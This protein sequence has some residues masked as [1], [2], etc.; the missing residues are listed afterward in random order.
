VRG[1]RGV[2]APGAGGVRAAGKG[3]EG[4]RRRGEPPPCVTNRLYGATKAANELLGH[5]YVA[6]W[7]LDFV[8]LRLSAAFGPGTFVAGSVAG[9]VM[10]ALVGAAVERRPVRGRPRSGR[11]GDPHP[12]G[13]ARAGAAARFP[14]NPRPPPLHLL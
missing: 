13:I 12:E 7:G 11:R 2:V 9:G 14:P 6:G 10:H 3:R 5:A 8:V 1:R 4:S